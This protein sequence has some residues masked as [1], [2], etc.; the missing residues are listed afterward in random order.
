[1]G[2]RSTYISE[3]YAIEY[4]QWFKDKYEVSKGG[5]IYSSVETKFPG[6][7]VLDTWKA[8]KEIKWFEKDYELDFNM[9]ML[10]ECGG[11]TKAQM[12]L[13]YLIIADPTDWEVIEKV[14]EQTDWVNAQGHHLYC[15]ECTDLRKWEE[16]D[17]A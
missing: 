9:V 4:P 6:E 14:T 10:H 11:I 12:G 7:V 3:H 1:M 15:Y 2:F 5:V 17:N 13:E 8:L 16:T